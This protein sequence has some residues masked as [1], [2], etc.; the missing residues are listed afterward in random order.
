ML[1]KRS[2]ELSEIETQPKIRLG[3]D[4]FGPFLE[5]PE[6]RTYAVLENE[7]VVAAVCLASR[8]VVFTQTSVVT[9]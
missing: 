6:V 3:L 9:P 2:Q 5:T 4:H 1:L 8:T 7:A